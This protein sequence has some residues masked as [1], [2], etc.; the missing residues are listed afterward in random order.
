VTFPLISVVTANPDAG[1]AVI[2]YLV[3][4]PLADPVKE[5][6]IDASVIPVTDNTVGGGNMVLYSVPGANAMDCVYA[7]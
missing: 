3:I 1:V 2:V 5:T 6:F 7:V 4:I